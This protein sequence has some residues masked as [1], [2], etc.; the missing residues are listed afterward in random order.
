MNLDTKQKSILLVGSGLVLGVLFYI[1][2]KRTLMS[3]SEVKVDLNADCEKK[4]EAKPDLDKG[5]IGAT[6]DVRKKY[7]MYN[8]V[9]NIT[10][11]IIVN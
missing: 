6:S 1:N 8:C 4:W 3:G 2:R 11:Q 7:F 10:P 9:N 5:A